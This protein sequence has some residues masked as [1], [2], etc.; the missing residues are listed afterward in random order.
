MRGLVGEGKGSGDRRTGS[1]VRAIGRAYIC[2]RF[3]SVS[4]V[5]SARL[6]SMARPT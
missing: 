2:N 5:S 4:R 3:F 1:G 6:I